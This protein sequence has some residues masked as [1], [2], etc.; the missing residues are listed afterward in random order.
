MDNETKQRIVIA[1]IASR[2]ELA[3]NGWKVQ[4][5]T[6]G[7]YGEKIRICDDTGAADLRLVGNRVAARYVGA[8]SMALTHCV[9]DAIR[10]L[11]LRAA[12]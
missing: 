2:A 6:I 3:R 11:N 4:P 9:Q 8:S 10:A 1:L 5:I 12:V 7:H